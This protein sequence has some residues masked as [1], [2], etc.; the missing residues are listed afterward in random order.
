MQQSQITGS[1]RDSWRASGGVYGSRRV[2]GDLRKI[3]ELCG[4]HRVARIIRQHRI[5]AQRGYKAPRP[6]AG[7]PSLLAPNHLN[8]EFTTSQP[9]QAWVTDITYIRT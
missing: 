6:I 3:G 9:D 1:V 5:K 2:L 7:R 8:R 4:K